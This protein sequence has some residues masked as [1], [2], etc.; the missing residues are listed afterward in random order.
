MAGSARLPPEERVRRIRG[1]LGPARIDPEGITGPTRG[2]AYGP[3]WRRT[4]QGF[5]VPVTADT[6]SD[7]QRIVEAAAVLPS[8]GAVTGWAALRWLGAMWFGGARGS[9]ELRP[10]A[11]LTRCGEIRSQAGITVSSELRRPGE[12]VDADGVRVT[13]PVRS[14]LFEVRYAGSLEQAV[15]HADMAMQADLVSQRELRSYTST[16]GTWTGVPLARD[17]LAW[18]D[19]NS[20]S[21]QETRLRL[22]WVR[23]ATLPRPLCNAPVF[24]RGG[25]HI[26]TPDL[27]DP[28][29][30]VVGEYE[31]AVHLRSRQRGVDVRREQAFRDV[32]LEYVAWV[33]DDWRDEWGIVARIRSAYARAAR[34]PSGQR[35]WSMTA[36]P[37]WIR[38][39]TVSR[40]RAL[41]ARD[42]ERLLRYRAG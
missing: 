36:P 1:W 9:G 21:P 6:A 24:D 29:A 5:F 28:H 27:I 23:L 20:W 41:S 19:E 12:A 25:R 37:W 40:R 22:V 26:G 3:Q 30:G 39:D 31:G 33:G 18:T 34:T 2:E 7:E 16:L 17:A 42:R 35:L 8:D 38:T 10:V 13:I 32:G 11:V 15:V 4:S 14:T